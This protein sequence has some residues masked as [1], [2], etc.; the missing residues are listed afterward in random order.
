MINSRALIITG[1][2]F[3]GLIVLIL[4]LF[5]IQISKHEYYAR[6]AE[7]QQYKPHVAQADRG[8]IK[9]VNEEVLCYTFNNVSFFVDKAMMIAKPERIDSV[10][11]AFSKITG[12]TI[13]YYK[14]LIADG[15]KSVCIENKVPMEQ[16]LRL[17]GVVVDGLTYQEDFN[18][19]YPYGNSA[20][21][22]LGYV[23][24]EGIGAEGIE[25]LFNEDLTGTDG[26]YIYERDVIGRILSIDE[27]NSKS[28]IPGNNINLTINKNYQK[29]LEEEI[30]KGLQQYGG[31]SAVGIVMNPNT[32][33]ILA[34][35]NSPDFDPANYSSVTADMR[36][37]RAVVDTYEPGS[38]MKGITFSIL[39]DNNLINPNEVVNAEN[40]KYTYKGVKIYDTHNHAELT[41]RGVLEQSSNIGT[42]KLSERIDEEKFFQYLRDFGLGNK[43]MVDLPSE[44]SGSLKLPKNFT[45]ITKAFMSFGYELALTPL[46]LASA[47]CAIVNGGV[48]YKPYVVK[49]ITDYSGKTI[50]ENKPTKIRNVIKESTS[51]LMRDL[52]I[53][54]VEKGSGTAAK[55]TDVMVG[56]KTGT[57][58]RLINNSYSSAHHN[59]SFVGFFPAEKPNTVILILV[60]SPRLGQYGGLV[61]APIFHEVA[62]RMIESDINLVP[63]RKKIDRTENMIKQ[64]IAS[65]QKNNPEGHVFNNL[66]EYRNSSTGRKFSK[67]LLMPNLIHYS[68]R[69]AIAQLNE[70]GLKSKIHGTGKVVWQ[71]IEPGT[72]FNK[73]AICSLRC[74]PINKKVKQ[75]VN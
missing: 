54:V 28:P 19:V 42:A 20:S 12:R 39:L 69:D 53:G 7:T 43:T 47:Y 36:R 68:V 30:A 17:R 41:V 9:D 10:A 50:K 59:S 52:M 35:T 73:S 8:V 61:A 56:G 44:A 74:E 65:A 64:V 13:S 60:N 2:L 58:Q 1:I 11:K 45:K 21:H 38:T 37:N 57:S 34:L 75:T 33:E 24:K 16:A 70:M 5:S 27:E 3:V 62:K 32:G 67:Q 18:R 63:G 55:L 48:L 22:I 25:K 46:Q 66:P 72:R 40:G 4:K 29:I 23:T 26:Y 15:E 6:I 31:E 51:N 49:S 14:K 71:N